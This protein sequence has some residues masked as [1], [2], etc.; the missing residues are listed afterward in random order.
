MDER[1]ENV[2]ENNCW[3]DRG[4]DKYCLGKEQKKVQK[5]RN[6]ENP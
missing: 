5:K 2:K 1:E 3:Q 4:K 6:V